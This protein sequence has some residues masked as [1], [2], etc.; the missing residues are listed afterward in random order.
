MTNRKTEAT[1]LHA[2]ILIEFCSKNSKYAQ[3]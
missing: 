1:F 2:K 3:A